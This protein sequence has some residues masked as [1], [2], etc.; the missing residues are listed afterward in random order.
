[1][2]VIVRCQASCD[3]DHRWPVDDCQGSGSA[4]SEATD[5]I[6]MAYVL[7]PIDRIRRLPYSSLWAL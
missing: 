3:G 4:P 1:M 5:G 2:R 7:M 6:R